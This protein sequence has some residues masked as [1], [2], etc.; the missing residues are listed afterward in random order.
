[1]VQL[2]E[3]I[4]HRLLKGDGMDLS[5]R[6]PERDAREGMDAR[7]RFGDRLRFEEQTRQS[8]R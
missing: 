8:K 6:E 1:M 7:E 3:Q 2:V 5:R 4:V